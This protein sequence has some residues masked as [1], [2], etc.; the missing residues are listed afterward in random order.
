[1]KYRSLSVGLL[2][3]LLA[4]SALG[5]AQADGLALSGVE[6]PGPF[7][8]GARHR[9][10]MLIGEVMAIDGAALTVETEHRGTVTVQTNA[11]TRFRARDDA[12]RSVSL[13][14]IQVGDTIGAKGRFVDERTLAARIVV[15]VPADLAD[16]ARGKVT[17]IDGDT[18][19]VEGR[20]GNAVDIITSPDTRFRVKGK[21][22]A[23]IDD[24]EVGM[25][26]GAAG[27]FDAN[28][29][30]IARHVIA[31]QARERRLPKG[32]PIA[33]G[34]VAEVKGGEFVINYPDGSTLTVTTDASTLV[35]T[36]GEDGPALGSLSDVAAGARALVIGVPSADGGSI[37]A[38]VI[39]VGAG[40][41]SGS[42]HP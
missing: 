4:F 34:R 3:G 27:Q 40:I 23:S 10:V 22:D 13:A 32:G 28:G 36:R 1:M 8:R 20:D 9:G 26:V 11:S 24:V 25:L 37:A 7:G 21:P 6:G 41:R 12:A 5:V 14:D 19:T 33:G 16:R 31:G 17:A 39:V 30:L 29:A 2:V 18:I 42:P 35:I 15:L 38:R